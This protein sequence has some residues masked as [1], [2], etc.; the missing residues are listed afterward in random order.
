MKLGETICRLRTKA[1]FSQNDLAQALDV[2][3]QSVSKWETGASVPD[4]DKLV[5]LAALFGVSLDELVKGEEPKAAAPQPVQDTAA[6]APPRRTKV[7]NMGLGFLLFAAVTAV[8]GFLFLGVLVIVIAI[9]LLLFGLVLFFCKK[10]PVLKAFWAE[11]LMLDAYL[12]YAT[13]I[14]A[15]SV[16]LTFQ[17]TYEMNYACLAMAWAMLLFIIAL[18]VCTAVTL[19][20]DGWT[21]SKKQKGLA[22]F[23]AL[24][25]FGVN[26]PFY[27]MQDPYRIFGSFLSSLFLA[28]DWVHLWSITVLAVSLFRWLTSRRKV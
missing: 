24:V 13:G 17:W 16:L 22:V 1:G 11:F 27:V 28:R 26:L 23:A 25:F 5:K 14:H 2:S 7:Q 8:L 15:S 6:A 20:K 10:H 21:G 9:P 3:R 4:L 12:R 19:G 18:V